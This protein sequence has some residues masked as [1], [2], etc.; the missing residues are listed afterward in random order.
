MCSHIQKHNGSRLKKNKA[1]RTLNSTLG[2]QQYQRKSKVTDRMERITIPLH[3]P[4]SPFGNI[5]FWALN[6]QLAQIFS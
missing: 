2:S 6:C 5:V 1:V 4:S 3:M